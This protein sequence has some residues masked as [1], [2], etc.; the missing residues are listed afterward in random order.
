[1][2]NRTLRESETLSEK[3]V[4]LKNGLLSAS[5]SSKMFNKCI[6]KM[7]RKNIKVYSLSNAGLKC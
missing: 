4:N 3:D 1:M 7:Y 2:L 5:F 6:L